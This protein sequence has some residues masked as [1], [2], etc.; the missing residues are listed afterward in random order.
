VG[1]ADQADGDGDGIGDVCDACPDE[2]SPDGACSSTVDAL[3]DPSNPDHPEDG[4][5][6]RLS[7]LVVTGVNDG[8]G[9]FAQDPN[10]SEF[11]GLYVYDPSGTAPVVG[12]V[13]DV[14][15]TYT[16]YYGLTE[17]TGPTV[18]IVGTDE[19]VPMTVDACDIATGGADA[20]RLEAMLLT[21]EGVE[22]T[23]AN[24]DTPDDYDEFAVG[25]CLRIDDFLYDDLDQPALGTSYDHITGVT[26]WSFD[27]AKLLP[28]GAEDLVE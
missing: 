4:S 18:D 16:E 7:G 11:A 15:G 17:L 21:V 14:S 26:T 5:L 23:D 2:A 6:V 3:R 8:H 24:P 12:D 22:V 27:N 13:V 25:G 10:L 1:N 20:E 19:I 28:R 9:F